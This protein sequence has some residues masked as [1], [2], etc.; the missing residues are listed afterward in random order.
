MIEKIGVGRREDKARGREQERGIG[1]EW[2]EEEMGET[3]SKKSKTGE[4]TQRLDE[5]RR[6]PPPPPP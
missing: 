1:Q 6:P 5:R 4:H 2:R 3:Y